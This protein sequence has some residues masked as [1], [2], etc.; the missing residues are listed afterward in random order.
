MKARYPFVSAVAICAAAL[1]LSACHK[2]ATGQVVAVVNGE[3]ITLNELN[4]EIGQ[5]NIPEGAAGAR[6][7]QQVL[8]QIIDRRLLAQAAK[9]DGID[10]DPE[11]L[12]RRR[13]LEEALLVQF[14]GKR[15]G[16][17]LRV[18]DEAA[19]NRFMAER[20]NM[21]ANRQLLTLDQVRFTLPADPN[22][23][24]SLESA[25]TMNDV[26]NVLT[27]MGVRFERGQQMLDTAQVPPQ[28]MRQLD[29][30][31]AGE[32]FIVP[33]APIASVSVITARQPAPLTGP[34]A[35]PVAVQALRDSQLGDVI[36]RRMR[37]ARSGAEITYQD[38]FAPP[39]N[40]NGGNRPAGAAAAPAVGNAAA[41]AAPAPAAK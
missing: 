8:Q 6:V 39:A 7:R 4:T 26:V 25:K 41:P 18:P 27:G 37:E 30:L 38:G 33:S 1:T 24:R 3:E 13:Q 28:M 16:S 11:Y 5:A 29:N 15:V 40:A 23:L 32:P 35:R 10:T 31:P 2:S 22:R 19:I 34:Q 14:L 21:F 9:S 20:P 17:S 36:Q 12:I